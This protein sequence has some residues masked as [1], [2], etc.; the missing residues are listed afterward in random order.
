MHIWPLVCLTERLEVDEASI[1]RM[2]SEL[3][4]HHK[5]GRRTGSIF[6]ILSEFCIGESTEE[7]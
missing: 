6:W 5:E 7:D 3:L 1:S 4:E 2:H